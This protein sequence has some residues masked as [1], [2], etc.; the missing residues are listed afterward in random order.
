MRYVIPSILLLAL[1]QSASSANTFLCEEGLEL[2]G[3]D[4]FSIENVDSLKSCEEYCSKTD[5][6]Q[7]FVFTDAKECALKDSI[8]E[9][10]PLKGSTACTRQ[11][12]IAADKKVVQKT[13]SGFECEAGRYHESDLF[14]IENIASLE[15]CQE[16]CTAIEECR[17]LSYKEGQ[18]VLFGKLAVLDESKKSFLSCKKTQVFKCAEGVKFGSDNVL[19]AV[20]EVAT[21]EE[22]QNQ[23]VAF[24]V[25]AG[26]N[27]YKDNSCEI[28]SATTGV[29]GDSLC[30]SCAV[31]INQPVPETKPIAPTPTTAASDN[32]NEKVKFTCKT[33]LTLPGTD[34]VSFGNIES[35]TEC[36]KNC[37]AVNVCNGFVYKGDECSLKAGGSFVETADKDSQIACLKD[38]TD[39]EIKHIPDY[40]CTETT[41]VGGDIAVAA[42]YDED[43]C[44]ELCSANDVCDAYVFSSESRSCAL[45]SEESIEAAE[46]S[47]MSVSGMVC[48]KSIQKAES[49]S[50][51]TPSTSSTS[52]QHFLHEIRHQM[53]AFDTSES[54][55]FIGNGMGAGKP[56]K[57]LTN[58]QQDH[59]L[60]HCQLNSLCEH[61]VYSSAKSTCDLMDES[62][63]IIQDG[64]ST[65]QVWSRKPSETISGYQC[66]NGAYLGGTIATIHNIQSATGCANECS[67]TSGCVIF[68]FHSNELRCVLKT[69]HAQ[70][71]TNVIEHSTACLS[72]DIR[73]NNEF[74]C[75]ELIAYAEG[76]ISLIN[77]ITSLEGCLT[78][79]KGTADCSFAQYMPEKK[80]CELKGD[81]AV[82]DSAV[83]GIVACSREVADRRSVGVLEAAGEEEPPVAFVHVKV[84]FPIDKLTPAV[85]STQAQPDLVTTADA[86]YLSITT[87][88]RVPAGISVLYATT[89]HHALSTELMRNDNMFMQKLNPTLRH[90]GLEPITVDNGNN[91]WGVTA[92]GFEWT[93]KF[94]MVQM[95]VVIP[96][97]SFGTVDERLKLA[98]DLANTVGVSSALVSILTI[99][100]CSNPEATE[101]C[102]VVWESA[103]PE[104]SAGRRVQ[105][106]STPSGGIKVVTTFDLPDGTTKY[107]YCMQL[108]ASLQSN[109]LG[110][111]T[112]TDCEQYRDQMMMMMDDSPID[113]P[114]DDMTQSVSSRKLMSTTSVSRNVNVLQSDAGSVSGRRRSCY[115]GWQGSHYGVMSNSFNLDMDPITGTL[116]ECI[117]TCADTEGCFAFSRLHGA[118]NDN[119]PL[120][121]WLKK[122]VLPVVGDQYTHLNNILE[123]FETYVV[124]CP[125][126]TDPCRWYHM[127]NINVAGTESSHV[128]VQPIVTSSECSSLCELM[129]DC[130]AI[131]YRMSDQRCTFIKSL[132]ETLT[133]EEGYFSS[134]CYRLS[135]AK[136]PCDEGI[137]GV[138]PEN[139][140]FPVLESNTPTHRCICADGFECQG[141]C[142]NAVANNC[143]RSPGSTLEKLFIES[144]ENVLGLD[145]LAYEISAETIPKG[146]SPVPDS[147]DIVI[148]NARVYVPTTHVVSILFSQTDASAIVENDK[149]KLNALKSSI[150]DGLLLLPS[151]L[152]VK[153]LCHV[154]PSGDVAAC[155]DEDMT[156]VPV[157][158]RPFV[159]VSPS[160]NWNAAKSWCGAEGEKMASPKNGNA[161][162]QLVEDTYGDMLESRLYWAGARCSED[163]SDPAQW[164]WED[165]LETVDWNNLAFGG[166]MTILN[167]GHECAVFQWDPEFI[168]WSLNTAD[169]NYKKAFPVCQETSS[170]DASRA[171][172]C[173]SQQCDLKV[174][175]TVEL[176]HVR[177][178]PFYSIGNSVPERYYPTITFVPGSKIVDADDLTLGYVD[179]LGK[180]KAIAYPPVDTVTNRS[181]ERRVGKECRSR[182]S[183]YH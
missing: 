142:D 145:E 21:L 4:I 85:W 95:P 168:R 107:E 18:C 31:V 131:T 75:T 42:H 69:L 135:L 113:A 10:S 140:C 20:G 43:S 66:S 125:P 156:E 71:T 17:S 57:Q 105:Q 68:V 5:V 2:T 29:E 23:C 45:K 182:W 11:T 54:F 136:T 155:W 76:S 80:A 35:L 172:E 94:K 166:D 112:A 183:P 102:E 141:V 41:V 148:T 28:L 173:N 169:C 16:H 157:P 116:E 133:P 84:S 7:G 90:L 63:A 171:E 178:V 27:Y 122:T 149:V 126:D 65:D 143:V 22:C 167:K 152:A 137:C 138:N 124:S 118:D 153:H 159:K 3:S 1:S 129:P 179:A 121:C 49:K 56:I 164:S 47:P 144:L 37:L 130:V 175:F 50:V 123:G 74:K 72:N 39:F 147:T 181:E 64:E 115:S 52:P 24:T 19:F 77:D 53:E 92:D 8:G 78:A 127:Q 86:T 117:K 88:V 100:Q 106:L 46:S 58:I 128:S 81:S 99:Y 158:M 87:A 120:Q 13:S 26:V 151:K 97:T 51:P 132:P 73:K 161:L 59:C 109:T 98:R 32:A 139:D 83:E 30:T 40:T 154:L 114:A 177:S 93:Q 160:E 119:K 91:D 79:C 6:C 25:C 104:S 14:Y 15:S 67:K 146:A 82:V 61:I 101:N 134:V 48:R 162:A 38:D 60:A 9:K 12:D 55:S 70:Q 44:R 33:T 174:S 180:T 176:Q 103:T 165:S 163:C 96:Q 170:P 108:V 111:N 110:I 36:Q 62:S 34:L 89:V 150:I